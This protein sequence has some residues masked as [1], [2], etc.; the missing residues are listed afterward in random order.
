MPEKAACLSEKAGLN[1]TN[2]ENRGRDLRDG[3]TLSTR[4]FECRVQH[5]NR[6]PQETVER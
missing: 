3:H 4:R 6:H 5:T 1:V 2:S